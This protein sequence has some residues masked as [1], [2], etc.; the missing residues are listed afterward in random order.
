MPGEKNHPRPA[1]LRRSQRGEGR[2]SIANDGRYGGESLHVVQQCRRLPRPRY[3]RKR[4]LHARN[5]TLA[6]DRIQQRPL[7]AAFVSAP[8]RMR[9][10]VEI[11]TGALDVLLQIAARVAF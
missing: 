11:K 4:W 9:V 1:I 2:P 5:A 10:D 7:L 3:R 8:A 6:L